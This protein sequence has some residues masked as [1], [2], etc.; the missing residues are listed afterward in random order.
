MR[1]DL[2][3]MDR[4]IPLPKV[5]RKALIFLLYVPEKN[6]G[7]TE[8]ESLLDHP[9]NKHCLARVYLG[10]ANGTIDRR[11]PLRHFPLYLESMEH[12]DIETL[13][14]ASAMGKAHAIL[15]WSAA[16]N[17]DDVE[18]VLVDLTQAPNV[19]Y[20]A[21]KG[22]MVLGDNEQFIP[23]Y[24]RS[25]ALFATFLKGYIEAGNI[26]LSDERLK[27][28]FNKEFMQEYEEYAEDFL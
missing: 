16:I 12:I 11:A 4:I 17:S 23:H 2:V 15:H 27:N 9:A 18:F 24:S 28:K 20:Q 25:P 8:I 19:V 10:K 13:P 7:S 26:I 21:S 3:M 1:G 22:A 6:L 14:L 5:V